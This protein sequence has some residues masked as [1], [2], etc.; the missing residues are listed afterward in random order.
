MKFGICNEIFKGWSLGDTFGFAIRAG[1][2]AVEIAPFTLAQS[3]E[4]IS[5]K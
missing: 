1:Y 4:H 2:D 5:P 3:V